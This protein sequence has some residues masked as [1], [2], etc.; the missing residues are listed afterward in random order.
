MVPPPKLAS[1]ARSLLVAE[2]PRKTSR[3]KHGPWP[4]MRRPGRP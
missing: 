4:S 2:Q 1:E 3:R